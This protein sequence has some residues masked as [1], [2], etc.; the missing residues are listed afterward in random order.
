MGFFPPWRESLS[1]RGE[2]GYYREIPSGY[3]FIGTPLVPKLNA[4]VSSMQ[5]DVAR[6]IVQ[7][8]VLSVAVGVAVVLTKPTEATQPTKNPNL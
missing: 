1:I 3:G 8:L 6:L 7:W 5:I 2:N 4:N